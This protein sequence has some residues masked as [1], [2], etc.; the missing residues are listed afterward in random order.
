MYRR[1]QDLGS[2]K[3]PENVYFSPLEIH[4][5][6]IVL[7]PLLILLLK[8]NNKQSHCVG[9]SFSMPT[10]KDKACF[11]VQSLFSRSFRNASPFSVTSGVFSSPFVPLSFHWSHHSS[12]VAHLPCRGGVAPQQAV[13]SLASVQR[14]NLVVVFFLFVCF[15]FFSKHHYHLLLFRLDQFFS[16][17]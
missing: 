15:L 2:W 10:L 9:L 12:T 3:L 7:G 1:L 4:P 14:E 17:H 8:C 5:W 13:F 6:S 11:C 16:T